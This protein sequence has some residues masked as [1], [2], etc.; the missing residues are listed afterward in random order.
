[1]VSEHAVVLR[2]RRELR[3]LYDLKSAVGAGIGES[4]LCPVEKGRKSPVGARV[5]HEVLPFVYLRSMQTLDADAEALS[6]AHS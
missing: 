5:G 1:M 2:C 3:S 4:Q 6:E